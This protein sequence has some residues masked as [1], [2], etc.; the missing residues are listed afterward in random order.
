MYTD[1][2]L[3]GHWN[4]KR[5]WSDHSV[6]ARLAEQGQDPKVL[7][8][9]CSDSRVIPEQITGAE[10][11]EIFMMRNIANIVPPFGTSDDAVGAVIEYAVS[12]LHV[13][14]IVICRHTECGGIRALE[15][16]VDQTKLPHVARWIEFARPARTQVEALGLREEERYLETIKRNVL[17][18]LKNLQTY[19][20]VRDGARDG[21]L[22]L[23]GWLY[24]LE[25][26]D[27]MACDDATGQWHVLTSPEPMVAE[28]S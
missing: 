28:Q 11:G 12:H 9:G 26:G 13:S 16:H 15:G 3:S 5:T 1:K 7:W 18:Q 27:L 19:S 2:L 14:D 10:P 21:K 8:I 22:K 6:F 25:T 4:F 20:C 17:L 23:H 24:V